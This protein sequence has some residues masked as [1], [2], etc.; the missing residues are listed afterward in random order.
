MERFKKSSIQNNVHSE[1]EM[2][3]WTSC[4][5]N[6]CTNLMMNTLGHSK[7]ISPLQS[8]TKH[9]SLMSPIRPIVTDVAYTP[10]QLE[11]MHLRKFPGNSICAD[12]S[13]KGNK[14]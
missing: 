11:A 13:A 4:I 7:L 2:K 3:E 14:F 8:R 12:C 10:E 5:Q 1:Q 9:R 6:L